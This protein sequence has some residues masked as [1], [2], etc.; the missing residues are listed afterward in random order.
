[1]DQQVPILLFQ[2]QVLQ[3]LHLSAVLAVMVTI[4]PQLLQLA[5]QVVVV[6]DNY[7]LLVVLVL[8]IKVTQVVQVVDT[9]V[10]VIQIAVLAVAVVLVLLE[11][12]IQAQHRE[13]AVLE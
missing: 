5:V 8:R 10:E 13:L 7:R 11:E 4:N 12:I 9:Q 6:T 1:M 3:L 2:E